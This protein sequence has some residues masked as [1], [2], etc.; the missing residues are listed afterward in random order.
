[1]QNVEH[2]SPAAPMTVEQAADFLGLSVSYIYRLTSERRIPHFK[3]QGGKRTYFD[4]D[5][6]RAWAYGRRVATEEDIDQEAVTRV[7]LGR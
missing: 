4:P 5:D 6:L 2:A 3:S 7:V 1:M